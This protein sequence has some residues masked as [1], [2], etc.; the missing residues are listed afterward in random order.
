MLF[1][2][3][4]TT[5]L[6]STSPTRSNKSSAYYYVPAHT[7]Q[8]CFSPYSS[9]SSAC[10]TGLPPPP[11]TPH[12]SP[13]CDAAS[14]HLQPHSKWHVH[15]QACSSMR[16]MT[17]RKQG[18]SSCF[19]WDLVSGGCPWHFAPDSLKPQL[20]YVEDVSRALKGKRKASYCC[21]CCCCCC[22]CCHCDAVVL[23]C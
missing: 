20:L 16:A 6:R 15:L 18:S 5:F 8:M 3:R 13:P 17:T 10:T 12:H 23:L 1:Y 14:S 4:P 7:R 9:P 22:R 21:C 2:A 19:S 11:P